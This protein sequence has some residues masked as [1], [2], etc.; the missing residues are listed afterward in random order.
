M[1]NYFKMTSSPNWCFYQYRVDFAPNI[2]SKVRVLG[3]D[4]HT[5][6]A[7]R[8]QSWALCLSGAHHI[9]P[10][11]F[12][13]PAHDV[14]QGPQGDAGTRALVRRADPLSA[15]EAAGQGELEMDDCL[16]TARVHEVAAVGCKQ[17][18]CQV[19]EPQ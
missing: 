5:G 6:V 15:Q 14:R 18:Q 10:R 2:D 3:C 1:T 12:A 17:F 9:H 19:D 13:G 16:L 11:V 8:F 4:K 7:L